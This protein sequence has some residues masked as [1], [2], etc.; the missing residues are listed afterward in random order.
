MYRQY[1][2]V[3]GGASPHDGTISISGKTLITLGK[4]VSLKCPYK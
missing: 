4:R 3:V 2:G 1:I